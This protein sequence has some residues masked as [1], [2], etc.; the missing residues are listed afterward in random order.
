MYYRIKQENSNTEWI[1][2]DIKELLLII[3]DETMILWTYLNN[4][5]LLDI[6]VLKM[7]G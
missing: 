7:H 5:Y 1:F 3:L 4:L 2:E 6:N